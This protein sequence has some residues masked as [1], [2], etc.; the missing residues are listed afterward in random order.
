[1]SNGPRRIYW[2]ANVFLNYIENYPDRI[3]TLDALLADA[4]GDNGIEIWTST[5]TIAEVAYAHAEHS[6]RVLDPAIEE[7]FDDLWDD[8][9][10][11]LAEFNSVVARDAR[12]MVRDAM[13]RN[14]TASRPNPPSLRSADAV[15]LATARYVGAEQFHTYDD[16]LL[17]QPN[18][19]FSFRIQEPVAEQPRLIP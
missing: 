1:M 10:I 12:R 7:A 3:A 18:G 9:T 4:S 16:G 13:V 14:V 15:H 11:R 8:G 17:R 5:F 2:D 6:G 19:V